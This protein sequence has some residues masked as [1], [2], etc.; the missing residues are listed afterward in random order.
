MYSVNDLL[1]STSVFLLDGNLLP[2]HELP[3]E[4]RRISATAASLAAIAAA[5]Y[6]VF[7]E[8]TKVCSSSI[9]AVSGIS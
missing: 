9:C 3:L 4:E 5:P 1:L 7:F 2:S 6:L 8:P